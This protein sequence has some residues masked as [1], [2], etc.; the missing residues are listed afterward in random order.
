LFFLR[1]RRKRFA[2]NLKSGFGNPPIGEALAFGRAHDVR[3]AHEVREA[4]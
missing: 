3:D 1:Q 4:D 2:A